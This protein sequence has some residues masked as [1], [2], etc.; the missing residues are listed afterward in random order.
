MTSFKEHILLETFSVQ[1]QNPMTKATFLILS[2]C[3]IILSAPSCANGNGKTSSSTS[4][5]LNN[6]KTIQ[7]TLKNNID[8]LFEIITDHEDSPTKTIYCHKQQTIYEDFRSFNSKFAIS[9]SNRRPNTCTIIINIDRT[10]KSIIELQFY[11]INIQNTPGCTSEKLTF[12]DDSNSVSFCQYEES[13]NNNDNLVPTN[14]F[15]IQKPKLNKIYE[16]KPN[17][18]LVIQF[19]TR[20]FTQSNFSLL[21]KFKTPAFECEKSPDISPIVK[22]QDHSRETINFDCTG[23]VYVI[24]TNGTYRS[25]ENCKVLLNTQCVQ[26]GTF[27]FAFESFDVEGNRICSYDKLIIESENIDHIFCGK[28][29]NE[30]ISFER[31][32]TITHHSV[33]LNSPY[34]IKSVKSVSV[35]FISDS[36]VEKRGIVMKTWFQA[37]GTEEDTTTSTV[38]TTT[39]T[40]PTTTS[41]VPT[42]TSENLVTTQQNNNNSPLLH[43]RWGSRHNIKLDCSGINYTLSSNGIYKPY[44]LCDY[45]FILENN[46]KGRFS[47]KYK[48]VHIEYH[49]KCRYDY[50]GIEYN[51]QTTFICG[52]GRSTSYTYPR[53]LLMPHTYVGVNLDTEYYL[54]IDRTLTIFFKTDGSY[55]FRGFEIQANFNCDKAVPSTVKPKAETTVSEVES[56]KISCYDK[57]QIFMDDNWQIDQYIITTPDYPSYYRT[58]DYNCSVSLH[59]SFLSSFVYIIFDELFFPSSNC[60]EN[61]LSFSNGFAKTTFCSLA[62]TNNFLEDIKIFYNTEFLTNKIYKIRYDELLKIQIMLPYSPYYK[63]FKL[64]IF[65][66][67][68]NIPGIESSAKPEEMTTE[69]ITRANR[70]TRGNRERS[71]RGNRERSTGAP[72]KTTNQRY[73]KSSPKATTSINDYTTMPNYPTTSVKTTKPTRDNDTVIECKRDM[74][75]DRSTLCNKSISIVSMNYPNNHPSGYS[76]RVYFDTQMENP[77]E[78]YI[79]FTELYADSGSSRL[80]ISFNAELDSIYYNM[81]SK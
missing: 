39:S 37:G 33:R 71:T 13:N 15:S 74:V 46:L 51:N 77:E 8:N 52:S 2:V 58:S 47:L 45:N 7:Q 57:V 31:N 76:C 67:L 35:N 6:F 38:P 41:T 75:L 29:G 28:G 72:W 4:C 81:R 32:G 65:K 55:H 78:A 44:E 5:M 70:E 61:R 22:C 17:G 14:L 62:R 25:D 49:S 36:N 69:Y 40:V 54:D 16:I 20:E 18:S 66:N 24:S 23:Q 12:T 59:T 27:F 56:K 63:R 48:T 60:D 79:K 26:T 42:T 64:R 21:A 43:C 80:F 68:R 9:S 73:F 30:D 53:R 19:I 50:L 3:L 11:D 34:S 10:F 1:L